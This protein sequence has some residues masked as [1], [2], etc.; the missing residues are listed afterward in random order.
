[1]YRDLFKNDLRFRSV[2]ILKYYLKLH[3]GKMTI[4]LSLV[5]AI[6]VSSASPNALSGVG[7]SY[8]HGCLEQAAWM[9]SADKRELYCHC[10]ATAFAKLKGDLDVQHLSLVR[11]GLTKYGVES[12]LRHVIGRKSTRAIQICQSFL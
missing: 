9:A 1:M 6:G 3:V 12:E 7:L 11:A 8:K 4:F 10:V 5:F 2:I